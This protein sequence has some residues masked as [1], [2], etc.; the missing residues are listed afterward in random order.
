MLSVSQTLNESLLKI[1]KYNIIENRYNSASIIEK[2]E[3]EE[4]P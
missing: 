2:N 4:S 3:M 1:P